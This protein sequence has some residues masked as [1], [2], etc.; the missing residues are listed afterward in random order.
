MSYTKTKPL[1]IR[2]GAYCYIRARSAGVEGNAHQRAR[3]WPRAMRGAITSARRG[4][5]RGSVRV[6]AEHLQ[7]WTRQKEKFVADSLSS[8]EPQ[9]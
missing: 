2:R 3:G 8:P 7:L 5:S 4:R 6:K 9:K 1:K